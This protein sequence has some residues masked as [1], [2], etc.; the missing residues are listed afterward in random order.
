MRGNSSRSAAL[1]RLL[2][3]GGVVAG[4]LFVTTF[5]VEGLAG[6][7]TARFDIR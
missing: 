7:A 5:L 4:P 2:L 1:T 6:R 3:W